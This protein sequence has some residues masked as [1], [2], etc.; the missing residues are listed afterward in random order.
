[1]GVKQIE[2][3]TDQRRFCLCGTLFFSFSLFFAL[4]IVFCDFYFFKKIFFL[5]QQ[6]KRRKQTKFQIFSAKTC[7]L[8]FL[9][10]C[11]KTGINVRKIRTRTSKQNLG[12]LKRKI[13][14][15]RKESD[16]KFNSMRFEKN[17]PDSSSEAKVMAV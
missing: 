6:H 14:Q 3:C 8:E 2:R 17:G 12:I 4:V 1:L 7:P 10:V 11:T 9:Q 16:V 15:S 5:L 13:Q